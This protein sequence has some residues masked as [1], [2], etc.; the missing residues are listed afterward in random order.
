MTNG[1]IQNKGC[2]YTG[3]FVLFIVT[4]VILAKMIWFDGN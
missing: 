1:F 4:V 2:F 3:F